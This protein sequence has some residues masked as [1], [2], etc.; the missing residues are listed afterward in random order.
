MTRPRKLLAC[1]LGVGLIAF[2][3][4][5][6][7]SFNPLTLVLPLALSGVAF[8]YLRALPLPKQLLQCALVCVY[9]TVVF[10]LVEFAVICH[11][12][13]HGGHVGR[14]LLWAME[15][16]VFL[17]RAPFWFPWLLWIVAAPQLVRAVLGKSLVWWRWP[18]A[19][20]AG[21]LLYLLSAAVLFNLTGRTTPSDVEQT[22]ERGR[23]AALGPKVQP[24][25]IL[26]C[27][28]EGP[29]SL[30]SRDYEGSEWIWSVYRPV[31]WAWF[32]YNDRTYYYPYRA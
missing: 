4:T 22:D 1:A 19:A 20:V 18:L 28:P 11:G 26:V 31:I 7:A 27:R 13:S 24:T 17:G 9:C 2:P 16:T 12:T 30:L 5:Q 3:R 8:A 32:E 23:K 15:V 6:L 14:S 10:V 25:G 29:S 21:A